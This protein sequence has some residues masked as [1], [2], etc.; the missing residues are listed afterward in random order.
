MTTNALLSSGRYDDL[1]VD[2]SQAKRAALFW[3]I[4]RTAVGESHPSLL[5]KCPDQMVGVASYANST[6]VI[7]NCLN[8]RVH[9]KAL[10]L[11]CGCVLI[12]IHTFLCLPVDTVAA[13]ATCARLNYIPTEQFIFARSSRFLNNSAP[14]AY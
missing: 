9:P 5:K 7:Q 1:S 2:V 10:W 4:G 6:C 11:K 14:G 8:E 12:L 13:D 3:K